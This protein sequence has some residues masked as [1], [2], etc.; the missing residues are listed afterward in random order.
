MR[1]VK[2]GEPN[3]SS[4]Q[5]KIE[6][7][8][9]QMKEHERKLLRITPIVSGFLSEYTSQKKRLKG[10]IKHWIRE[11]YSKTYVGDKW[12]KIRIGG[13]RISVTI[14]TGPDVII[15]KRQSG[16]HDLRNKNPRFIEVKRITDVSSYKKK[17]LMELLKKTAK[18]IEMEFKLLK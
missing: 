15:F 1:R 6:Q 2:M 9:E 14:E 11:G 3:Q 8:R 10:S 4:T 7:I 18:A 17:E 5:S 13:N 12:T 16:Y